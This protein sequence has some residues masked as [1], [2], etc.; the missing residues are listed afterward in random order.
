MSS[1]TLFI[2]NNLVAGLKQWFS[3]LGVVDEVVKESALAA[4]VPVVPRLAARHRGLGINASFSKYPTTVH[5][6]CN[7]QGELEELSGK[8]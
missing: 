3:K 8:W 4:K 2:S 7:E 1:E 5:S 6:D